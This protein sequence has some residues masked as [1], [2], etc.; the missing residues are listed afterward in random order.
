MV[1]TESSNPSCGTFQHD[2]ALEFGAIEPSK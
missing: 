2:L 1:P